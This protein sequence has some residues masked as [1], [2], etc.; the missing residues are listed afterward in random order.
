MVLLPRV[1]QAACSYCGE[2]VGLMAIHLI[3]LAINEINPGLKGILHLF[4]DCLKALDKVSNQPTSCAPLSCA[5]SDVIKN[6]L[7]KCSSLAFDC[8]YSHVWVHQDDKVAY[9]DLSRPS[10]LNWL[11]DFYAKKPSETCS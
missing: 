3:L 10:Q 4:S 5:H 2:L 11:M 8:I 9:Q 7:V 1:C 6:L